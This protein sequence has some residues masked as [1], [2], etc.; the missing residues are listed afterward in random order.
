MASFLD[1]QV[2]STLLMHINLPVYNC[3]EINIDIN[4]NIHI[5]HDKDKTLTISYA[6]SFVCSRFLFAKLCFGFIHS[7][8]LCK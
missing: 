1:S 5:T 7:Y 2:Y 8:A 4:I 6:W 3:F